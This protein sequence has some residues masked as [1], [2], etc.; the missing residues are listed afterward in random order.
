MTL[1]ISSLLGSGVIAFTAIPGLCALS[2][3]EPMRLTRR[4]LARDVVAYIASLYALDRILRDGR[5]ELA[6]STA[7]LLMCPPLDPP[8]PATTAR[9]LGAATSLAPIRFLHPAH[10]HISYACCFPKRTPPTLQAPTGTRPISPSSCA[11]L[12]S[13]ATGTRM[14]TL[15]T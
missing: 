8:R 15:E 10:M 4:P 6:E 2:V 5:V 9:A 13:A 3:P 12:R 14:A 1:A 7:L 11:R